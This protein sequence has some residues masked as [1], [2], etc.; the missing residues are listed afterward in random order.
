MKIWKI[1]QGRSLWSLFKQ[2]KKNE[3][4]WSYLGEVDKTSFEE[5]TNVQNEIMNHVS[6]LS[7]LFI[8]YFFSQEW[9]HVQS[10]NQ[11]KDSSKRL[12]CQQ[13]ESFTISKRLPTSRIKKN[14]NSP[15]ISMPQKYP[16]I[17]EDLKEHIP[18]ELMSM[19]KWHMMKYSKPRQSLSNP[20]IYLKLSLGLYWP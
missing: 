15:T 1:L 8:Y 13:L 4:D 18:A 12:K 9:Q 5:G 19:S 10:N 14:R 20:Q 2:R 6:S 11:K 16:E 7:S 17:M 3:F